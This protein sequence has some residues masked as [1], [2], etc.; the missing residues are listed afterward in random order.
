MLLLLKEK[1]LAVSFWLY[2]VIKSAAFHGD[3]NIIRCLHQM[4]KSISSH[5]RNLFM[6]AARGGH[7]NLIKWGMN[8]GYKFNKASYINDAVASGNLQ[9]VKWFRN[10]NTSWNDRNNSYAVQSGNIEL[11]QYLLDNGCVFRSGAYKETALEIFK[12]LHQSNV[13]WNEGAC[14]NAATKGNFDALIYARTNGCAWDEC[15]YYH[16]SSRVG[17]F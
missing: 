2:R 5:N 14:T 8:A 1:G 3:L 13:P 15:K 9:L 17:S 11:L 6:F 16:K 12:W 10:Q 4:K 7:L